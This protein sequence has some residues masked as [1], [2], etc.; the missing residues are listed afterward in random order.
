MVFGLPKLPPLPLVRAV[1]TVRYGLGEAY[2]RL[3]P[4]PL[5]LMELLAAGW[6]AQAIHAA[7]ALG[8]A[9]ELARGPLA[10]AE[11]ARRVGANEDA[12]RRL[13]RLLIS[14]GIFAQ[15]RDGRYA[16]TPPARALCRDSP[17]S[18]RDAALFFGSAMHRA[19]WTHV[20][21]AVR[22]GNPVGPQVDG[23][24][25]FEY[26]RTDRQFGD[27][28]D[29]AM[30]SIGSLTTESLFAA[31]DFGQFSTIVDV[32]GG[33]GAMLT[34]ILTRAPE[35]RGVLFDLPDVVAGGAERFAAAG[36]DGRAEVTP[37]S[38]FESVPAGAEAY[39]LKHVVHD[40]PDA[41]AEQILRTVRAAMTSDARLII[42]E[43]V[44]PQDNRPHP[45]KYT[46]LEMLIN[47]GGRE[48]TAGDYRDLL[49]RCGFELTRITETV[50]PESVIE[51]RPV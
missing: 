44:L 33:H 16:L 4:A 21:D 36:F 10:G 29:R 23:A 26:I 34:E 38:F 31:Y 39:L 49:A 42:V 25:F 8:I 28:F 45:G 5:S 46:D 35:T 24:P 20:V 48:R 37:G 7:A 14:H 15:R 3:A 2:R 9:D 13:L 43:I 32:G 17:E 27:L 19:H 51:A 1:E 30:T 50:S 12:L 18:L 47:S 6:L 40:W 22:T 11:L 41:R